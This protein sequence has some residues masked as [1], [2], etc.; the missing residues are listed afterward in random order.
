MEQMA[1]SA[2]GAAA[3]WCQSPPCSDVS[4][5]PTCRT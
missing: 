4:P 2:A 5:R 1:T 3:S